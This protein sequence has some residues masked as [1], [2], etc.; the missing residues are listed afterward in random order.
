MEGAWE[1][2]GAVHATLTNLSGGGGGVGWGAGGGVRGDGVCSKGNY[3]LPL[4]PD[5]TDPFSEG[6]LGTKKK[7]KKKK[8]RKCC[9]LNIWR[10]IPLNDPGT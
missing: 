8:R 5:R 3:L 9:L 6:A 1:G 7:K 10:N 4:F 2:V